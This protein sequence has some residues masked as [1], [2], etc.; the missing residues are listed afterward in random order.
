MATDI[1]ASSF[2]SN[3]NQLLVNYSVST[4]AAA[5]FDVA[6]YRSADGTMLDAMIG[7][8]RI[9]A[10]GQLAVGSN[11]T[12]TITANFTDVASDYRLIAVVDAAGENAESNESNN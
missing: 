8:T 11:H 1:A 4:Q 10:A 3:N 9:T 12:A 6:V 2:T 7:S 5:A